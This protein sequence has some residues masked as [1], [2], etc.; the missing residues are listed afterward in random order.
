[1]P[2]EPAQPHVIPLQYHFNMLAE[3]ARMQAFKEALAAAVPLDACV[4]DL[5]GGTGVLSF[6]AAQRAAKVWCVE[7]NPELLAEARR[8]LPLNANSQRIE[9]VEAD[10][11]NYLPPEP[12]DMVICE[13]L[14]AALLE[15]QQTAVLAAFR[16]RYFEKYG[17]LPTFMPEASLLAVQPVEQDF[18]FMGFQAPVPLFQDPYK[19]QENTVELADP[20]MYKALDYVADSAQECTWTGTFTLARAGLLNALR[21]VSKHVL[22]VLPNEGR[23]IDWHNQY[24]VLPL[25]QSR[26][27][28]PGQQVRLRLAYRFG[29]PLAELADSLRLDYL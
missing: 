12:V 17:R 8:I 14:H 5:G 2:D 24:L 10:A 19:P 6:F 23:S 25:R 27:V 16:Q 4:V 7:R 28:Q 21:F 22:A 18:D 20:A 26:R 15:E 1:M 9:L 29:A 11:R 13:M 3:Y